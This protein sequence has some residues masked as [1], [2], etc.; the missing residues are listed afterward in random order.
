[1]RATQEA[2]SYRSDT[3]LL[4]FGEPRGMEPLTLNP[5]SKCLK[6]I[7]S[8]AAEIREAHSAIFESVDLTKA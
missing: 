8:A 7:V 3:K 5:Q 6:Q 2:G 1:M 4:I